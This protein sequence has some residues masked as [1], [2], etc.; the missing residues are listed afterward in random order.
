MVTHKYFLFFSSTPSVAKALINSNILPSF[1]G[2]NKTLFITNYFSDRPIALARNVSI[3]IILN[4]TWMWCF[5]SIFASSFYISRI[6]GFVYSPSCPGL[7]YCLV[8]TIKD[9][10]KTTFTIIS[11]VAKRITIANPNNESIFIIINTP[12]SFLDQPS[13]MYVMLFM[14]IYIS[15]EPNVSMIEAM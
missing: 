11:R 15:A 2:Q 6:Y 13:R 9:F 5:S 12:S 8:V 3:A 14:D 7:V 10:S 1:I 4:K